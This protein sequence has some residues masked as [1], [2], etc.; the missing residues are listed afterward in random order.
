VGVARGWDGLGRGNR[1]PH[2]GLC[3]VREEGWEEG[4]IGGAVAA[5]NT[6]GVAGRIA[7][8]SPLPRGGAH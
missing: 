7:I 8:S 5:E 6:G 1:A 4:V 2:I 3:G